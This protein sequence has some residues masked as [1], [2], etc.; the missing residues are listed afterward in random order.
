MTVRNRFA[1]TPGTPIEYAVRPVLTDHTQGVTHMPASLD[2]TE[3]STAGNTLAR[4]FQEDPGTL[5]F[6]AD[7]ARRAALLPSMFDVMI[8]YGLK[9]GEVCADESTLR[10]V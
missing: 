4:A 5:Y 7:P 2:P 3:L 8:R 1:A 6:F 9:R 10:G